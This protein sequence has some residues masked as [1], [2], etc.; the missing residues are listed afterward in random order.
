[1]KL[2][3]MSVS[4]WLEGYH[5]WHLTRPGRKASRSHLGHGKRKTEPPRQRKVGASSG[6]FENSDSDYDPKTFRQIY[7]WHHAAGDFVVNLAVGAVEVKLTTARNYL[8][9]ISFPMKADTNQVDSYC[10]FPPQ[11]D[12]A[13]ATG[14]DRRCG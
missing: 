9:L 12:C 3:V 6:G 7:P 10:C 4:E 8:P 13:D 11:H 1:M 14:Q 2:S 5:E